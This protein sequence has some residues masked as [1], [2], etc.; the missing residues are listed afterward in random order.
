[1]AEIYRDPVADRGRLE[2]VVRDIDEATGR[3]RTCLVL[4]QGKAH[5]GGFSEALAHHE[6]A[7]LVG[8]MGAKARATAMARISPG[9]GDAPPVLVVATGPYVGEGSDCPALDT[10][11]LAAPISFHGRLVQYA[12]RILRPWPGKD[13]AEVHDFV[14]VNVPVLAASF[15]RRAKGYRSLGFMDLPAGSR[16]A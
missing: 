9:E 15:G 7:L 5:V 13:V 14:D 4:T 6:P 8:A 10:L 12:G 2:L 1:M 11:F 16:G 3:G